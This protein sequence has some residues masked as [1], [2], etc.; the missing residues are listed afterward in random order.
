M[1]RQK[2]RVIHT[3]LAV[4]TAGVL[5]CAPG[6][7]AEQGMAESPQMA[8][9]SPALSVLAAQNDMAVA[10]L[11][12]NDYY[13]S[14]DVFA[15][16][17]NLATV[18]AIVVLSLPE[19]TEGEL[20]LGAERVSAGQRIAAKELSRLCFVAV[21]DAARQAAFTF[22]PAGGG[23][24]MPCS[25]HV[26]PQV[27][28]SPTVS[29]TTEAALAVSTYRDFVGYGTLSAYDPEGD[30]LL[31][32]VVKSPKDG[33]VV[34]TDRACGEYVYLPR[35]GFVG[36]DSFCYVARDEYGNYSAMAQVS[37]NC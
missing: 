9:I 7:S 14:E 1:K 26:L 4:L 37:D 28:Y 25:I 18:D 20:L 30:A 32:E 8:A 3:L 11:C 31:F 36:E 21:D 2:R 5:L 12:G 6:V 34:M 33:V 23:Y 13:F 22:S 16:S 24:E 19:V 15:R 17:L 29:L 10:T 27:N 35:E